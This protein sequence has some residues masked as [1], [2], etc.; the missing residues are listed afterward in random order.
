MNS[1][2]TT[3]LRFS[4]ALSIVR[5]IPPDSILQPTAADKLQFYGLYKQATEGDINIPRPSS[6]QMVDYAKWK[7]W[8]RMKGISP[9]EAQKLYIDSLIQLLAE[10]LHRYPRHGQSEFLKKAL[11]SLEY[12]DKNDKEN[13]FFQDAYD[14]AEFELQQHF[15][16]QIEAD[17]LLKE[18]IINSPPASCNYFNNEYPITPVT[19]PGHSHTGQWV[20]EQKNRLDDITSEADTIDREVAAVTANLQLSSPRESPYHTLPTP[21]SHNKKKLALPQSSNPT[22]RKKSFNSS[23]SSTSSPKKT[24]RA[25]EKLQTEVT[26]LTEQIDRLRQSIQLREEDKWSVWRIIKILLKH[27]MANSAIFLIVFYALWK[28]KSPIAYKLIDYLQPLIQALVRNILRKVVFWKI[29]V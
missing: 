9:I 16:N 24:D 22:P 11:Q 2:Y 3:Q 28:S 18:N 27:L 8:S 12:D 15:L 1:P 29:T 7:A 23:S 5:A 14:P 10:L 19:S 13:D 20:L 25:L 17:Q 26:A 4:H 6:R 21:S